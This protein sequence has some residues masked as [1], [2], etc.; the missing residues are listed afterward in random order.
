MPGCARIVEKSGPTP[1]T[2]GTCQWMGAGTALGATE[3]AEKSFR[4]PEAS[5]SSQ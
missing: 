5:L 4:G 2:A 1:V 3:V